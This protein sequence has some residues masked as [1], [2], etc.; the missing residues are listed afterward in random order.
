MRSLLSFMKRE[1]AHQAARHGVAV[2][3]KW[4]A[5]SSSGVVTDPTTGAVLSEAGSGPAGTTQTENVKALSFEQVEASTKYRVYEE[6]E[7]GNAI[8]DLPA[9]VTIDGRKGLVFVVDGV[10]WVQKEV[11]EELKKAWQRAEGE[12]VIQSFLLRKQT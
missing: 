12:R 9:D 7:V 10:E 4:F 8:I 1:V 6:V 5:A 11:G 3:L 2:T